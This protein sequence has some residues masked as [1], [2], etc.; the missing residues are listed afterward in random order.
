MYLYSR[1]GIFQS[2]FFWSRT[3]MFAAGRAP[4]G[5]NLIITVAYDITVPSSVVPPPWSPHFPSPNSE[6]YSVLI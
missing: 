1:T 4:V 3:F 2:Y 6:F 5:L